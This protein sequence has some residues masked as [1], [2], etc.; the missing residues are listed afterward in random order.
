MIYTY[1][2]RNFKVDLSKLKFNVSK[3]RWF[4][5][6]DGTGVNIEGNGKKGIVEFDPPGEQKNGN[7]WVLIIE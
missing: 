2:G 4:N 3:I 1:T 7:D 6:S 5:P